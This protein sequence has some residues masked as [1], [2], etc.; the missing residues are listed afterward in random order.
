[1]AGG[2]GGRRS[3]LTPE[4]QEGIVQALKA[5]NYLE[6]AARANGIDQS[7]LHDWVNR[8][9]REK[10]GKYAEFAKAIRD[11]E[12]FAEN[13]CVTLVATAAQTDWKAAAWFLERKH[14]Q[15]WSKYLRHVLTGKDGGPIE[16]A[17]VTDEELDARIAALEAL[18]KP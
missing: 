12:A 9:E 11:A 1:M 10:T 15:K 8:G 5:G 18:G 7:T 4:R 17:K 16:I 3:K 6:V 14:A 2:K 13:R